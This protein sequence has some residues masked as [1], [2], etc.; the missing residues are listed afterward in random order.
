MFWPGMGAAWRRQ[1]K[2]L[3]EQDVKELN[4][5][6]VLVETAA[7]VERRENRLELASS[8]GGMLEPGRRGALQ[9]ILFC[10]AFWHTDLSRFMGSV[11]H[12]LPGRCNP[13][14]TQTTRRGA[15]PIS[16]T[17]ETRSAG[18]SANSQ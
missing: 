4:L 2:A 9:A 17:F 12:R 13:R 14:N 3:R 1:G 10:I 8:S 16:T 6:S 15:K 5:L 18:Q 7:L 11:L